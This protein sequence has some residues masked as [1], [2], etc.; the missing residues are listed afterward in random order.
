MFTLIIKLWLI[1]FNG[2]Y[3][4][5]SL[6]HVGCT[7]MTAFLVIKKLDSSYKFRNYCFKAKYEIYVQYF[8]HSPNVHYIGQVISVD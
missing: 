4:E 1:V 3:Y 5:K 8:E 6:N 2:R 7:S